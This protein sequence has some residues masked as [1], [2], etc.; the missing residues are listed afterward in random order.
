MGGVK[1]INNVLG[2]NTSD[3]TEVVPQDSADIGGNKADRVDYTILK[4]GTPI[5]L[6]ECKKYGTDLDKEH[7]PQ[8]AKYFTFINAEETKFPEEIKFAILTNGIIYRFYT[9]LVKTH[10]LDKEPF[11]EFDILTIKDS[12]IAELRIFSNP[13]DSAIVKERPLILKYIRELRLLIDK[14]FNDPSEKFVKFFASQVYDGYVNDKV[15]QLFTK[16]TKETLDQY[17]IDRI[18]ERVALIAFPPDGPGI[19]KQKVETTKEELE[20]YYIVKTLLKDVI[21]PNKIIVQDLGNSFDILYDGASQKIICRLYLNEAPKHISLF[22]EKGKETKT[23]IDSI[24]DIYK[25][26][27]QIASAIPTLS[28]SF[29]FEGQKYEV[30]FWKDMLPKVCSIMASR[31]KDRFE[32]IFTIKGDIHPYFSRNPGELKSPE[33]IEGTDIYVR[34]DFQKGMLLHVSKRAISL[35]GCPENI[36]SFGED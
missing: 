25:Y 6:I 9:D 2:Y 18:N 33:L 24:D 13:L 4:D 23:A 16:L 10:V 8:L 31:H 5:I 26:S 36:I 22:N 17:I 29:V 30:K 28:K 35:F 34:T 21:N 12:A 14:E 1:V 15:K 7:I 19:T 20:G 11:L 27:E 32:D 3:I